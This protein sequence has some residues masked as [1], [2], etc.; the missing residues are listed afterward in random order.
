LPVSSWPTP[1]CCVFLHAFTSLPLLRL[2]S[3]TKHAV[4]LTRR[5]DGVSCVLSPSSSSPRRALVCCALVLRSPAP[6][7]SRS[8]QRLAPAR[9]A[10]PCYLARHARSRTS[11]PQP[12]SLPGCCVKRSSRHI[13]F[14]PQSV[15][16]TSLLVPPDDIKAVAHR[17]FA[18]PPWQFVQLVCHVGVQAFLT[19]QV[20]LLV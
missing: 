4:D 5:F 16:I 9:L 18:W 19:H 10:L 17:N 11:P 1:T 8:L 13:L 14:N 3:G 2:C 15:S 6:G 7:A 20:L 12:R